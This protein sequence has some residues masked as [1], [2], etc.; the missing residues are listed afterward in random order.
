MSLNQF[1]RMVVFLNSIIY[2]YSSHALVVTYKSNFTM[3]FTFLR[4]VLI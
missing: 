3:A 4:M 2:Q 1:W